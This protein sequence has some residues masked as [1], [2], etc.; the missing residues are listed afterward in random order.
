MFGV[1]WIALILDFSFVFL[2]GAKVRPPESIVPANQIK[3]S[4]AWPNIE[5]A[6]KNDDKIFSNVVAMLTDCLMFFRMLF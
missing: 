5:K 4:G 3:G 1:I 6:F 2:N